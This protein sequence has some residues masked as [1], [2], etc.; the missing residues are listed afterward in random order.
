MLSDTYIGKYILILTQ[1]TLSPDFTNPP[2]A[3]HRLENFRL[4]SCSW[5]THSGFLSVQKYFQEKYLHFN[6]QVADSRICWR[7]TCGSWIMSGTKNANTEQ[8][9]AFTWR[10]TL[11]NWSL[12]FQISWFRILQMLKAYAGSVRG[13]Q[14]FAQEKYIK[15]VYLKHTESFSYEHWEYSL[16]N[17]YTVFIPFLLH[18]LLYLPGFIALWKD[19]EVAKT[20]KY[21]CI[22]CGYLSVSFSQTVI[23]LEKQKPFDNLCFRVI[24]SLGPQIILNSSYEFSK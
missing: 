18:S 3:L 15:M 7:S 24:G 13:E 2:R 17:C 19:V 23:S 10:V 9:F 5:Y 8:L 14:I 20:E 11:G 12:S 4:F 22:F 6:P 21:T 1:F 16:E